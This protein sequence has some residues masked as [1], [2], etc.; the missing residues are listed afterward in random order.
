MIH[1]CCVQTTHLLSWEACSGHRTVVNVGN[2]G[3]HQVGPQE[4]TGL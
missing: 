4:Q 3:D 2:I 1:L